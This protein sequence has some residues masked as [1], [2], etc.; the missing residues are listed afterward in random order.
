MERDSDESD[1]GTCRRPRIP[2]NCGHS[3]AGVAAAIPSL[4]RSIAASVPTIPYMTDSRPPNVVLWTAAARDCGD[5]PLIRGAM[6]SLLYQTR[7]H[8]VPQ[9]CYVRPPPVGGACREGPAHSRDG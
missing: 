6:W 5:R 4:G 2:A 3:R 1:Q 7:M 9:P 8:P